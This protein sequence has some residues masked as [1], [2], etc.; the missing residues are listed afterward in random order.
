MGGW[1]GADGGVVL[2]AWC[3]VSILV[4]PVCAGVARRRMAKGKVE[5]KVEE[6]EIG[7]GERDEG[8]SYSAPVRRFADA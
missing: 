8:V 5:E 6:E 4:F 2:F 1:V 7:E 3:A